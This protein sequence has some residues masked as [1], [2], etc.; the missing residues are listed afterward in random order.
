MKEVW[1]LYC[2]IRDTYV[3]KEIEKYMEKTEFQLIRR[4]EW[5]FYVATFTVF[6]FVCIF[7]L[8]IMGIVS[9]TIIEVIRIIAG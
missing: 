8:L 4:F 6:F 1:E 2:E 5:D 3:R 9:T 7:A